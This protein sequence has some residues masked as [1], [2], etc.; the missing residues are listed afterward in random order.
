MTLVESAPRITL[1]LEHL[2]TH[3]TKDVEVVNFYTPS[4][5]VLRWSGMSGVNLVHLH[6]GGVIKGLKTWKVQDMERAQKIYNE[7]SRK[8]TPKSMT[9]RPSDLEAIDHWR[10]KGLLQ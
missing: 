3:E 2:T 7:L 6:Q 5:L 8:D 10:K 4:W 1:T 9:P